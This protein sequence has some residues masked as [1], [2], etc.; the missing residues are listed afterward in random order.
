MKL[1]APERRMLDGAE[2]RARRKAMEILVGLGEIYGAES[3]TPI[4]SAQIAGVS[5]ANLGEAG[6]ELIEDWAR[7]GRVARPATLN[8]AGMDLDDWRA[9][10]I[11]EE[12]ARF[13][14]RVVAA[15]E[16]MGVTPSCTCT[17]YL[18]GNLPEFGDHIAWSESSAV[19]YANSVIGAR[20]NREGGP[21]ALAAALTGLTPL[22]GMHLDAPRAPTI[23]VNIEV[24]LPSTADFGALGAAIGRIAPGRV[25]LIEGLHR[26][27]TEELKALAAALPTFGGPP[28][29]HALGTT[30]ESDRY[31]RPRDVVAIGRREIDDA[32]A[33][34]DDTAPDVDLVCIGCPHATIDEIRHIVRLLDGR[35]VRRTL[36]VATSRAVRDRAVREG[37][38]A[39]IER[40]GGTVV[41]DTCFV[42]APLEGRFRSVATDSAKGCY[43]ARGPNR[44][45]VKL[46][47][48]ADC[49]DLAAGAFD[50]AKGVGRRGPQYGNHQTAGRTEESGARGR[51]AGSE[52][53]SSLPPAAHRLPPLAHRAP[54]PAYR[55]RA[56]RPGSAAGRT[57]VSAEAVSFYGG[58]DPATGV[59]VEKG[60]PLQGR[61]VAGRVLVI[62]TGK[63]S[64]VGSYVLYRMARAGTAPA[65]ILCR[66]CDPVVAAGV[67]LGGIP[68]VDRVDV[69]VIPDGALVRIEGSEVRIDDTSTG[70]G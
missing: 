43:Y 70:G 44:M 67:I 42:V 69:S 23:L 7:D 18:A 34:L 26:A 58:V 40:S 45:Q 17:P 60:H 35:T 50:K 14:T 46:A 6:L 21:S 55:G 63:G 32:Y 27:G 2:G 62:P 39:A 19:T 20:T 37:L 4:R 5:Y 24:P 47:S 3:M 29:F 57:V 33:A 22:W 25:P 61:S 59:V 56:V 41:A 38:V 54:P 51:Q 1:S 12:F 36:W 30:P 11:P 9:H 8:P 65:G 68:C 49:V 53:A 64:T 28:I 15:Y 48:V 66:E 31:P 10:G 52:P 13:Q 16:R